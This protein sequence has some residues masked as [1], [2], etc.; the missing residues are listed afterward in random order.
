[1]EVGQAVAERPEGNGKM[2]KNK[3]TPLCYTDTPE[4]KT[5]LHAKV[6]KLVVWAYSHSGTPP[7]ELKKESPLA[8]GSPFSAHS[9]KK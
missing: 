7:R 4:N 8:S 2:N 5:A 6:N 1:M 3:M 9:Y